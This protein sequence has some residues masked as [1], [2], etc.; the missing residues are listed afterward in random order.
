MS[1][2]HCSVLERAKL[3]LLLEQGLSR[4]AI[5]RKLGRHPSTIS[6]EV[7]RNSMQCGYVAT[8]AQSTYKARRKACRPKQKLGPGPLRLYVAEK[9]VEE[10]WTPEIIANRLPILFPQAKHMRVS[11]E[12]IYRAIYSDGHYLDFLRA[13]LPQARAKRRMRGQG[14]HRRCSLIPNRVSIHDRPPIIETRTQVGHWE[15]DLIV[16]KGQD[17]FI[18]TLTERGARLLQGIKVETKKAAEVG[19]AVVQA[20]LDQPISWVRSITFDNG[21]EFRDHEAITKALGIPIY[22]ADPYSAYQRGTNEQ[23]NGLI[24]R[25]LPKGTPFKN[26]TQEKIDTIIEQIN[27]RPRKCLGYRTPYEVFQ[28]QRTLHRCALRA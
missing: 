13:Y 9:I 23:I 15:G 6:R 27:N 28:Q 17:G 22:F 11:H 26:L 25:Y 19:Q 18:L 1:Y 20:L 4:A 3:E 14:K 21:T 10:K 16:G 24:R 7:R 2:H 8:H 5:A 12:S